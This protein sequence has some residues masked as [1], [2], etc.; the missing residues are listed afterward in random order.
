MNLDKATY[1]QHTAT[2][3]S[4]INVGSGTDLSIKALAETIKAVVGYEGDIDFDPS[5]PDGSPRKLMDSRRLQM[6][7]WAPS[8][9]LE[10]GLAKAYADF[11]NNP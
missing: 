4:H 6:L 11:L 9:G 8:I 3:C 1:D 2:M 10:D 5:K 7:G